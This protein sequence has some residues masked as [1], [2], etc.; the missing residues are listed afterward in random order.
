MPKS[1]LFCLSHLLHLQMTQCTREV[2]LVEK[3]LK[4]RSP[5]WRP[6][7]ARHVWLPRSWQRAVGW[8]AGLVL[9]SCS[10]STARRPC[11]H[12]WRPH[13]VQPCVSVAGSPAISTPRTCSRR[14]MTCCWTS[15]V[16]CGP[17]PRLHS[18]ETPC[19]GSKT[20]LHII[21]FFS[22]SDPYFFNNSE[23]L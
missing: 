8:V 4:R 6:F 19:G 14:T 16:S 20:C 2:R 21:Q 17:W 15:P 10:L 23:L 1:K 13:C 9:T 18:M 7:V 22:Q 5:R 3:E 11:E 12:A